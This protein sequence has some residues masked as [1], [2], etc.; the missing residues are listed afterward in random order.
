MPLLKLIRKSDNADFVDKFEFP[1]VLLLGQRNV[2]PASASNSMTIY[3]I[4]FCNTNVSINFTKMK[5]LIP[6]SDANNSLNYF[7]NVDAYE[8]TLPSNVVPISGLNP[9]LGMPNHYRGSESI[10][11]QLTDAFNN[12]TIQVRG[13]SS[14]CNNV[15]ATNYNN[16]YLLR[17][18]VSLSG[19]N[20]IRCGETDIKTFTITGVSNANCITSYTWQVANK[21]WKDV[22][23]NL[24][25]SNI[26]TTSPSLQLISGDD[27]NN[28]P[29]SF[30]V[31]LNSN[32]G[33]LSLSKTISFLS[34]NISLQSYSGQFGLNCNETTVNAQLVNAPV[35]NYSLMWTTQ[36]GFTI[37]GNTSPQYTG[38][39]L[40]ASLEKA[41]TSTSDYLQATLQASCGTF[42]TTYFSFEGCLDWID[43]TVNSMSSAPMVPEP[44][45]ANCSTQDQLPWVTE[46]EWYWFDGSN[47]TYA[48]NSS[49]L[50]FWSATWP[51]G[52]NSLYVRAR[53]YYGTSELKYVGE[54]YGYCNGYRLASSKDNTIKIYPNPAK[55]T[56]NIEYKILASKAT[57][58]I[59]DVLG[60]I[61]YSSSLTNFVK[62]LGND[63]IDVSKLKKGMYI[64]TIN[65]GKKVYSKIFQKI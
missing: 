37:N 38:T 61:V 29:S 53:G 6:G 32:N 41:G 5:Y 54:Y 7:K 12:A 51:C 14:T 25:T 18:Q 57:I 16:I 21:G 11:V 43:F 44:F 27:K 9:I 52:T 2:F 22:N 50:S 20:T 30:S 13:I 56:L 55:N 26:T 15:Q 24:V 60:K 28:P 35:N 1:K 17:K 3:D 42:Q 40:N 64:V 39:I 33:S 65:D 46:F 31:V 36:N 59:T 4:P 48:G 19:I 62:I 45:L 23:G 8:Y 49:S 47:Y 63:I 34:P 10:I 58:N